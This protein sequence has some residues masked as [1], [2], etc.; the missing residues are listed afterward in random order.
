M[1]PPLPPSSFDPL[2]FD[3]G[4]GVDEVATEGTTVL[5]MTSGL[6]VPVSPRGVEPATLAAAVIVIPEI[7][8]AHV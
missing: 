5:M 8:R 3:A 1:V 2:T 4:A 7:G 6:G